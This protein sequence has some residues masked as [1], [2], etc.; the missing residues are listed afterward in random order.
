MSPIEQNIDFLSA[1]AKNNFW[2]I[3][4]NFVERFD[5]GWK[6]LMSVGPSVIKTCLA[7]FTLKHNF[8]FYIILNALAQFSFCILL[9]LR[10]MNH[11]E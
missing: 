4:F 2:I 8:Q 11:L 7:Q 1:A 5:I 6:I 10:V 9:N 3:F